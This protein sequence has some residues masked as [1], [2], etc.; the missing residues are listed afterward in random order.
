MREVDNRRVASS[1]FAISQSLLSYPNNV[2]KLRRYF[3]SV[4]TH[5]N[6]AVGGVA[7]VRLELSLGPVGPGQALGHAQQH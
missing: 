2:V 3:V 5:R 7:V 1:I 6:L 4:A